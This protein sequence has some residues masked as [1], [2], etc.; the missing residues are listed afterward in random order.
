MSTEIDLDLFDA[1]IDQVEVAVSQSSG[2]SNTSSWIEKNTAH[3]HSSTRPFSFKEHEYAIAVVNDTRPV[4]ALR[5]CTQ[6]GASE[7]HARQALA[8]T[9][10][11]HGAHVMYVMPS[12][13][14]AQMF[15]STRIGPIISGS[16]RL[17]S[18]LDRVIDST[19]LKKIG[20]SFLYLS[21]AAKESSA[22]SVPAKALFIDELAF[23]DPLV[24][25]VYT[26][27]LGH[28]TSED[29]EKYLRYFSSPL[30]PN[31]DISVYF[32]QGDQNIYMVYHSRCGQWVEL[33]TLR[34]MILP[35]FDKDLTELHHSDLD[36][37]RIRVQDAFVICPHCR[38]EISQ[39]DLCNPRKRAWVP[40]YPGREIGSYDAGPFVLPTSRTPPKIISELSKY[41]SNH[42][43]QQYALGIPAEASS[44]MILDSAARNAFKAQPQS[45][46]NNTLTYGLLGSDVGKTLHVSIGQQVRRRLEVVWMGTIEQ[47]GGTDAGDKVVR[48]FED[49][50]CVKGVMDAGPDLSL[51]RY[52]RD[53]L[54]TGQFWP[55]YF[56]TSAASRQ[57]LTCYT[58]T[59]KDN[60]AKV[61]RT[62]AFDEFVRDFNEG[63]IWLPAGHPQEEII[64]KHLRKMKRVSEVASTGDER[65]KWVTS[66]PA[67]HYFFSLFYLW[68]A[69]QIADSTSPGIIVLPSTITKIRMKAA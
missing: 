29:R 51:S 52:V 9:A 38:N 60:T 13:L 44:E 35:G 19:S 25:S 5:K 65:A 6:I 45:P 42:R 66:D 58:L 28:T 61:S 59:E 46:S 57:S 41:R 68:L 62:L 11:L 10:K 54:P 15:A 22:I 20:N 24:V 3:P 48:L 16:K 32:E 1:L 18:L 14:K 43:W 31:S 64:I 17:K 33:D 40:K 27:R 49:F 50:H 4:V 39:E 34:C 47:T 53:E 12:Q 21:G 30:H 69:A 56:V 55:T 37:P 2:L 8:M 7:A 36:N 67:N 23:C 63:N 26:S